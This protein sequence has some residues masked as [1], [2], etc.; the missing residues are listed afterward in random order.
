MPLSSAARLATAS[1]SGDESTPITRMPDSAIG[2]AMRPVPTAS[3]TTG[4]PR[5]RACST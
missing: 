1:I 3:S 4:P 5:A 2:I